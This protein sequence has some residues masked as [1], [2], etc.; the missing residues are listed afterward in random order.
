MP[1]SYAKPDLD[2]KTVRFSNAGDRRAP[3]KAGNFY[4]EN[5]FLLGYRQRTSGG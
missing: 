3:E 4:V 1:P 5:A 2:V